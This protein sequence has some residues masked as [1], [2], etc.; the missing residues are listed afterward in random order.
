MNTIFFTAAA[1][2]KVGT[3]RATN[4]TNRRGSFIFGEKEE[5]EGVDRR[6]ERVAW[7]PGESAKTIQS[8][9]TTKTRNTRNGYPANSSEL[10]HQRVRVSDLPNDSSFAFCVGLVCRGGP[11]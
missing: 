7:K 1:A 3:A 10:P 6:G 8:K 5:K 11:W 9:V 2:S 4:R